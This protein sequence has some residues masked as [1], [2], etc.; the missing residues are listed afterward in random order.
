MPGK[1]YDLKVTRGP[2]EG[3][4]ARLIRSSSNIPEAALIEMHIARTFDGERLK[5]DMPWTWIERIPQRSTK[6]QPTDCKPL[7]EAK[8]HAKKPRRAD[9]K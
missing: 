8:Q 4:R 9:D 6:Q 7:R 1:R 5:I 2:Y 3:C